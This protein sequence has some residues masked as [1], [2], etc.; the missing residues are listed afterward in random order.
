MTQVLRPRAFVL[1]N[2]DR[3]CV[4]EVCRNVK[5][6][7]EVRNA[8]TLGGVFDLIIEIESNDVNCLKEIIQKRIRS[9]ETVRSTLTMI[10]K[11]YDSP[12]ARLVG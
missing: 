7:P 3:G 5:S 2:I 10:E 4:Q 11:G 1:L 12:G 6:I 9:L 8:Y